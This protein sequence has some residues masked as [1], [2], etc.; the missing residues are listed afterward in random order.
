MVPFTPKLFFGLLFATFFFTLKA[1]TS[2]SDYDACRLQATQLYVIGVSNGD[3][4][5]VD[6]IPFAPNVVRYE[7][8]Y[9]IRRLR[10]SN[11]EEARYNTISG[12]QRYFI[13]GLYPG[14]P[15]P[16]YAFYEGDHG[17]TDSNF[18]LQGRIQTGPSSQKPPI[19]I[20]IDIGPVAVRTLMSFNYTQDPCLINHVEIYAEFGDHL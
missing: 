16:T 20:G 8:N 14:A 13:N 5:S 19:E 10:D 3:E 1:A 6:K 7:T 18:T 4:E 2:D 9:G 11:A 17:I 15:A 12:E